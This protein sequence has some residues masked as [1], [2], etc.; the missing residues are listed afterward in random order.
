MLRYTDGTFD[1][2]LQS[3]IGVDFVTQITDLSGKRLKLVRPPPKQQLQLYS[4]SSWLVANNS[5]ACLDHLGYCRA[6]EI[7]HFNFIILSR[8]TRHFAGL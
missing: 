6:R 1:E 4:S 7:P 2:H 3:T 8:G 5:H